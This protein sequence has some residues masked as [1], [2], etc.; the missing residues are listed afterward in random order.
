MVNMKNC[1][2]LPD[3]GNFCLEGTFSAGEYTCK[4]EYDRYL[5]TQELMPFAKGVSAKTNV[6]DENG[7][8]AKMDYVRLFKIVKDSGFKGIVGIEY[9]GPKL[10]EYDGIKATKKLL[11]K[12]GAMV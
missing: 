7:N 4:S 3:L 6:F 9:E 12:V 5:G 10:S 1:G 8:E 2:T 11:E